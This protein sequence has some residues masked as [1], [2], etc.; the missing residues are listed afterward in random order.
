MPMFRNLPIKWKLL[1][2]SMLA[3]ST[4]LLLICVAFIA[5]ELMMFRDIMVRQLSAQAE[6]VGANSVSALLFNDPRAAAE[7]LAAL[8]AQPHIISAGIYTPDGRAFATYV[9]GQTGQT[10]ALPEHL[11]ALEDGHRFEADHL[12]LLRRIVSDAQPIGTVY[13]QTG[14]QEM[15]ARVNHYLGIE[16]ID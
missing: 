8:R 16:G 15:Q 12:L 11:V 7:T 13:I 3:S 6:I 1:W 2:V 9:R 4:A 5:Y 10:P 14:L